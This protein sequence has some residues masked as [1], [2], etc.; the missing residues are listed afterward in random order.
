MDWHRIEPGP[1]CWKVWN[2]ICHGIAILDVKSFSKYLQSLTFTLKAIISMYHEKQFHYMV[3]PNAAFQR[4]PLLT[5]VGLQHMMMKSYVVSLKLSQHS[6]CYVFLLWCVCILIVIYVKFWIICFI[7]LFC[8]LFLCK[9][10]LHYCL[11]VLTQLQLTNI[12][13]HTNIA[14]HI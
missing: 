14:K 7:V 4:S 3:Q 12:S 8:V 10:V 1:P 2:C 9:C 5:S 6:Y 13:Y 11:R